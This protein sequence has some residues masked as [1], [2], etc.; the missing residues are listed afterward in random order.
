MVKR[1]ILLVVAL[2]V[3]TLVCLTGCNFLEKLGIGGKKGN[4]DPVTL[5][6]PT[7]TL[8]G[9]TLSWTTVQNADEYR[10]RFATTDATLYRTYTTTS[11]TIPALDVGRYTVTVMARSASSS[12]LDGAYSNEVTIV[13]SAALEMG[14]VELFVIDNTYLQVS[15][16]SVAHAAGYEVKIGTES[17]N[18]PNTSVS[19]QLNVPETVTAIAVRSLG[20]GTLYTNSDWEEVE[21]DPATVI[22]A[23]EL[24]FDLAD[25]EL[26]LPFRV[27]SAKLDQRPFTAYEYRV[28]QTYFDFTGVTLGVAHTL[29]VE[30]D[31]RVVYSL[32]LVDS[33]PAAW[34]VEE[35]SWERHG[36][37]GLSLDA[38]LYANQPRSLTLF[39][40]EVAYRVEQRSGVNH[41]VV[42]LTPD[43]L[44]ALSEGTYDLVL[45]YT[46]EEGGQ[47]TASVNLYNSP[48]V[49]N[50]TEYIYGGGDLSVNITTHGDVI[51]GLRIASA[52]VGSF[53]YGIN[54][55][56]ISAQLFANREGEVTVYIISQLVPSGR[57]ITVAIG[58]GD[59]SLSA[60]EYLY[61]KHTGG[62][63]ALQ[64]YLFNFVSLYGGGLKTSDYEQTLGSNGIT[65]NEDYLMALPQGEYHYLSKGNE[66]DTYFTV[67]VLDSGAA[68]TDVRLNYDIDDSI[69]YVTFD[70]ECGGYDHTIVFDGNTVGMGNRLAVGNV[71]RTAQHTLSVACNTNGKQTSVTVMAPPAAAQSYLNTHFEMDGNTADLYVDS[72]EEL[73][74]VVKWLSYAG[75]Y[76]SSQGNYGASEVEVFLS[77]RLMESIDLS[78]ALEEA[79]RSFDV[80]FS[81]NVG[82]SMLGNRLTVTVTFSAPV[83]RINTSGQ[84]TVAS[85]DTRTYLAK[86]KGSDRNLFID[87]VTDTQKVLNVVELADLP[88][89]VRPTFDTTAS[90]QRARA[91]YDA[92]RTVCDTYLTDSMSLYQKVTALYEYLSINVT[93]DR[94]T[95]VWYNLY[96]YAMS[97]YYSLAEV[98][99]RTQAEQSNY[100]SDPIMNA[101]FLRVLDCETLERARAVLDDI[102][103]SLSVFDAYGAMIEHSAVC[104]GISDAFRILCLIEGIPCLKVTGTGVTSSGSES[105]AW[106]KVFIEDEW[107]IVDATWGR[108]G[109][110][111][112]HSWLLLPET[113]VVD[114]HIEAPQGTGKSVVQQLATGQYDYFLNTTVHG[115]DLYIES[116]TEFWGV[117]TAHHLSGETVIEFEMAFSYNINELMAGSGYFG[118]YTTSVNGNILTIILS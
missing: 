42:D 57:P 98:K 115:H 54:S 12:Y 52:T 32:Y 30:G 78:A 53:T 58:S 48:F 15:W 67:T 16:P 100:G 99:M 59:L 45:T 111:V 17:R 51:T 116:K 3:F 13:K 70:C 71:D 27:T 102:L 66:V 104:D 87:S 73:N 34:E 63:L 84:P 76:D 40:E 97:E 114:N 50:K 69:A 80:P 41:L 109:E 49:L 55:L 96:A 68:P 103:H 106:N 60:V 101:N 5:G 93:Y 61:D 1:K 38:V 25:G 105:H 85:E 107:Y 22:P 44:N 110:F 95:L 86:A 81:S 8:S 9:D 82:L 6:T 10:V 74:T 75:N 21:F 26:E 94:Y 19:Y 20:D 35:V 14:E 83:T 4:G 89:G 62:D 88:F 92:A 28:A 23:E 113:A 18:L 46:G 33:R 37:I 29:V 2:L 112:T 65:L 36:A 117:F 7:L 11:A 43:T 72:Q 39:G 77:P 64:G 31:E 56:T 118:S 108:N 79:T 91:V 24:N 47:I 90:S